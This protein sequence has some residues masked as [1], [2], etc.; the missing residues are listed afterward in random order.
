MYFTLLLL[1]V[2]HIWYNADAR[3]L[4]V[5]H[6]HQSVSYHL[7]IVDNASPSAPHA[8][9]KHTPTKQPSFNRCVGRFQSNLVCRFYDFHRVATAVTAYLWHS[10]SASYCNISSSV[11][12]PL[13][14]NVLLP[15]RTPPVATHQGRTSGYL[16]TFP[17]ASPPLFLGTPLAVLTL[18]RPRCVF[19]SNALHISAHS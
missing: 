10:F 17:P 5:G 12:T 8:L 4:L 14:C 3:S 15:A 18:L 16:R 13:C 19:R 2:V 9:L 6:P 1:L 11:A 7:P